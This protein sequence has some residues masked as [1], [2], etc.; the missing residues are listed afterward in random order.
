MQC[1]Q[2]QQAVAV[3]RTQLGADWPA[4]GISFLLSALCSLTSLRI[5]GIGFDKKR[6][7]VCGDWNVVGITV[8]NSIFLGD[9]LQLAGSDVSEPWLRFSL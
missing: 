9:F 8:A 2:W 7:P 3:C 6:P 1:D 5:T 4:Y